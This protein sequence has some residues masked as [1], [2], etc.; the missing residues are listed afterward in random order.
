MPLYEYRCRACGHDVEVI[1]PLSRRETLMRRRE[2]GWTEVELARAQLLPLCEKCQ[3]IMEPAH[4]APNIAFKTWGGNTY[5]WSSNRPPKGNRKIPTITLGDG[6]GGRKGRR[7]PTH[8]DVFPGAA[9]GKP[10]T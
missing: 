4:G 10:Y 6:L 8:G 2:K 9:P 1:E 5:G 3:S 7:P